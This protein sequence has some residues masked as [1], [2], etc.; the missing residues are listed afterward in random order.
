MH[1]LKEL[2][3][4]IS[5]TKIKKIKLLCASVK[6]QTKVMQLYYGIYNNSFDSDEDAIRDLYQEEERLG[7]KYSKLKNDLE[8]RLLNVILASDMTN[9][10]M[11][12]RQ[13]TFYKY[14]KT[15]SA[16]NILLRM[17]I[18]NYAVRLL[19]KT[20]KHFEKN[21]FTFLALESCQ[22]LRNHYF[23]HIGDQRKGDYYQKKTSLYLKQYHTETILAG[24]MDH[25][26][27]HYVK[28]KSDTAYLQQQI[29]QYV[30]KAQQD[31]PQQLNATIIYR[32]KMLEVFK[33]MN[34]HDY[35]Q[36]A[37]VCEE[38]VQFFEKE[39]PDFRTY[40]TIFLN[41]WII[42]STQ[43]K[44]YQKAKDLV[45][46]AFQYL[47]VGEYNW[48]KL[49]EYKTQLAFYMKDYNL[50]YTTF[51]HVNQHPNL[52]QL[53]E[54]V[55]EKW[56]LYE[57]YVQF[58]KSI[59]KVTA[60]SQPTKRF[61][62]YKFLNDV[63]TFSKDKRGLN[64]PITIIQSCYEISSHD[65]DKMI[66]RMEAIDKYRI[67]YLNEEKYLRSNIFIKMLILLVK[68]DF[69]PKQTS[70]KVKPYLEELK[71][72]PFNEMTNGHELEIIPYTDLWNLTLEKLKSPDHCRN[73]KRAS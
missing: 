56:R 30:E 40:I 17:G 38:A 31:L 27:A 52:S 43:L 11:N 58:V 42:S 67:R 3:D 19:E 29:D 51:R 59:G 62:L 71:K 66:N 9:P 57:A 46:Q 6:D 72:Y 53:P 25:I 47:E 26:V 50:A 41:Q 48:F 60:D 70:E 16:A 33:Y 44:Q 63:N 61:R 36:T 39:K 12:N 20:L 64:I 7:T 34:A 45:L 35:R 49:M 15:W 28:D 8:N 10:N 54:V 18:I 21:E 55:Q 14:F 37:R 1:R 32:L 73:T 22:L 4:L 23:R 2:V 69:C 65:F 5:P 24:Y 13:R 68:S